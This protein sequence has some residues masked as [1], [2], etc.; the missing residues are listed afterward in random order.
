MVFCFGNCSD[1]L[2]GNFVIDNESYKIDYIGTSKKK[3]AFPKWTLLI[4]KNFFKFEIKDREFAK[5]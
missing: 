5:I 2:R 1:Q 3:S 4:Q